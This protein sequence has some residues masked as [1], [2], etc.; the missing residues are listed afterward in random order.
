MTNFQ[1]SIFNTPGT[2]RLL[3]STGQLSTNKHRI[4]VTAAFKYFLIA[5][6][7]ATSVNGVQ[8]QKKYHTLFVSDQS[9]QCPDNQGADCL[10]VKEKKKSDY[11]L[12][13]G[14]IVGFSYEEGYEYQLKVE[15]RGAYDYVLNKVLKKKKTNYN[16]AERID[17]KQWFLYSMHIDTQFIRILD[18]TAIYMELSLSENRMSG[19]GV[20]NRFN[21][22]VSVT[23]KEISF[24]EI[25][26][27]K[28]AC[29]GNVLESIITGM[30]KR[31]KF[32]KTSG[33]ILTLGNNEKELMIWKRR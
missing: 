1:F 12:L 26:S 8:A 2:I 10:M 22:S 7:F 6:S 11:Q 13:S 28:M 31:M 25:A 23:G 17:K 21:G 33:N 32:F 15:N 4:P 20:C 9:L 27:T 5:F 30:L 3:T 19:K 24:T 14:N 18:T 16:P 29:E